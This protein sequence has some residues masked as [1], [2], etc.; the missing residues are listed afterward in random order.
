MKSKKILIIIIIITIVCSLVTSY[1]DSARVRNSVEP[2]YVLKIVSKDGN[3]ITYWGLGYKVIR[4]PS[5]S[6]NEPYKN[7]IGAKYGHWLMKYA[8]NNKN[9]SSYK[10]TEL[11]N[12]SINISNVTNRSATITIKDYNITKTIY[13]SWYKIEKEI[14]SKWYALNPLIKDNVWIAIGYLVDKNNELKFDIDWSELY[15]KLPPGNYR[16]LK[17]V[18]NQYIAVEFKI[19]NEANKN[20]EVPESEKNNPIKFN[21][22]LEKEDRIIYIS[23]NIEEVY[24]PE[25]DTQISLKDYIKKS[26]Q[27]FDDAIKSLTDKLELIGELND[28]GTKIYASKENNLTIIRCHTVFENND[29]Y[30]GDY[31]MKF[32]SN[33]MCKRS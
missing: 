22:Y 27:T 19:T 31:F 30:I 18:N 10:V 23:T 13:G 14:D 1:I 12:I 16:I 20:I 4:Y 28:G 3:K 2:K 29:I 7:N 32:D 15:G 26:Y 6:P 8:P 24:L 21:K 5:V 11:K 9:E 33:L 17:Q 25:S